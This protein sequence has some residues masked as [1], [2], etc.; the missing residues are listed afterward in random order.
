MVISCS[1]LGTSIYHLESPTSWLKNAIVFFLYL[2]E[3]PVKVNSKQSF[4]I[5][6]ENLWKPTANNHLADSLAV[7]ISTVGKW[8]NK[9][10]CQNLVLPPPWFY[11]FLGVEDK[12]CTFLQWHD[13]GSR[14]MQF[15]SPSSPYEPSFCNHTHTPKYI[16]Q[17]ST[18]RFLRWKIV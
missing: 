12:F 10:A 3:K 9:V 2:S 4:G 8:G 13:D 5:C 7:E 15:T 11:D 1:F 6:Q 17:G 16:Q 14:H 18:D